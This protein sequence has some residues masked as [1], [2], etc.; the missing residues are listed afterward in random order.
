MNV[1]NREIAKILYEMADLLEIKGEDF[2]PR[3]YRRAAINIESLAVDIEE[4]YKR[5]EL[6][7]IPGVGKSI[8][9]KISHRIL[10]GLLPALK[11]RN[12]KEFGKHLSEI[13]KLVGKHFEDYQGGEFR[14]D[15]KLIMEFL[16]E[17]TYGCGQ[18]SW[19]PTVYGL[20]KR[21]EYETIKAKA[22][23][24]LKAHGIEAT[25]ELGLP[26]NKGAA[27]I[28][29]NTYILRLINKVAQR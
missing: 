2:K 12:I 20:I 29:E 25:V 9:E 10:L 16:G 15:V 26:R 8:A 27:V 6:E 17:N 11:E 18:S 13:Q 19:G 4:L 22:H 1:K 3:A 21:N 7:K 24:F 28:E 5:N 23:D 14:E